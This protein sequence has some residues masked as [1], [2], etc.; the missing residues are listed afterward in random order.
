MTTPSS[1]LDRYPTYEAV[2]GI[3]VHVQL[4]T[5]SKIFCSCAN[6]PGQKPNTNICHICTGH[7]G[8]LPRFNKQVIDY[9]LR[10]GL[11]TN[12]SI[13]RTSEFD[14]KHY[15]NRPDIEFQESAKIHCEQTRSRCRGWFAHLV[16]N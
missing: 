10:A 1:V 4:T 9:A 2:I 11:A 3:E 7:P 5:A 16:E 13:T 14:R 15:E 8:V 6:Q 12:C